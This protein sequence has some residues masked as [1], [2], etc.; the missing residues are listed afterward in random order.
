LLSS[1]LLLLLY[2]KLLTCHINCKIA[3]D[4]CQLSLLLLLLPCQLDHV[5]SGRGEQ[6]QWASLSVNCC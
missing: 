1:A 2:G 3:A 6:P 5:L 4:D